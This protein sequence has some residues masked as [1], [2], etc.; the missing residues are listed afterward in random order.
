MG[1]ARLG[2]NAL[3]LIRAAD[4]RLFMSAASWWELGIKR[5][6]GKLEI[7][8]GA[9]RRG[10]QQR[11][12]VSL[13]VTADHAEEA[14][15]LAMRHRDPFDHMLVAQAISENCKLLTRDK[16]LLPYGSAVFLV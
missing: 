5:A 12:V 6:I 4:S 13:P 15:K 14:T 11:G 1:S 16:R 3:A 8:I 9:V 7:D 10:L 2:R